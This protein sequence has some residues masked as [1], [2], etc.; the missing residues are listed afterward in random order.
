MRRLLLISIL[1]F[2]CRDRV[3]VREERVAPAGPGSVT[4]A[5]GPAGGVIELPGGPRLEIAA[6]ALATERTFVITRL[7]EQFPVGAL[8]SAYAFSP[9]DVAF[10]KPAT[11]SFPV[12]AGLTDVDIYWLVNGGT[13]HD[14]LGATLRDGQLRGDVIRLGTAYLAPKA[15]GRAVWGI[16]AKPGRVLAI[17]S[18]A[19]R[20]APCEARVF[21]DGTYVVPD[22]RDGEGVVLVETVSD[23]TVVGPPRC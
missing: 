14:R 23:T 17:S 21:A 2:G 6:G 1:L 12:P 13:H 22:V 16:G 20:R 19:A 3:S 7:G 5:I 10:R 11:V 4:R 15:G 18:K 8:S 9:R